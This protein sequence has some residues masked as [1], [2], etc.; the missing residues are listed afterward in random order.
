MLQR[1][2]KSEHLVLVRK[3][4]SEL[5]LSSVFHLCY[6][7][8][9]RANLSDLTSNHSSIYV[10]VDEKR[11]VKANLSE[12]SS[13][14]VTVKKF[15]KGEPPQTKTISILSVLVLLEEVQ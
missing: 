5:R 11:V 15:S 6:I 4:L 13:I 1:F 3:I 8:S 2:G 14:C 12:Q 7:A 10:T 9:V